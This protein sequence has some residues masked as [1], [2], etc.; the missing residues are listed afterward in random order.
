MI[1]PYTDLFLSWFHCNMDRNLKCQAETNVYDRGQSVLKPSW[2]YFK[3]F[4]CLIVFIPRNHSLNMIIY[5]QN[6]AL[7]SWRTQHNLFSIDICRIIQCYNLVLW[8]KKMFSY[9]GFWT[10]ALQ[11]VVYIYTHT[12]LY[13]YI[14]ISVTLF[15]SNFPSSCYISVIMQLP[16]FS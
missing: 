13:V 5:I 14:F 6:G 1:I 10:F 11:L 12:H 8:E 3:V 4:S 9:L 7:N 16:V 15:S 2:N